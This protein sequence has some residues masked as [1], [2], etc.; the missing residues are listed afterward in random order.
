MTTTQAQEQGTTAEAEFEVRGIDE[1]V[2]AQLLVTDDAGN[3]PRVKID[4][5]GGSPLRC[6]LRA[7]RPGERIAL[8]SYAPLRRWAKATGADPGAY[9]EVGPV[10]IH[11]EPCGGPV[12]T[13]FPQDYLSAPRVFRAYRADG[14][15]LRGRMA[16]AE[17]LKDADAAGQVLSRML[18]DPNVAVVHA[19]ALE[20]GCFTF[21][22][23]R[24]AG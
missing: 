9:D 22:V 19:R 13:R 5:E 3:A 17:V 7:S 8:V 12:S 15:I 11:T 14:S 24:A 16:S 18:A 2:V 4:D 1:D 23:R 10:F 21:E 6:C 20:F